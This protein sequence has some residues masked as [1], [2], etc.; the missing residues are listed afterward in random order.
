MTARISPQETVEQALAL[1]KADGCVVL[2]TEQSEANLRWANNTVTTNGEMRS[3][4]LAVISFV[5]GGTGMAAGVVEQSSTSLDVLA[6]VVRASE[7][8]A[9]DAGPADDDAP[10]VEPRV[11]DAG[12][13]RWG[14]EAAATSIGVF[15]SFA[16]VLGEAFAR[17][18]AGGRRLFGFA[19]HIVTSTYL[20]SSTGLRLRHDQPTGRVEL[21]AKTPEFAR[22]SWAGRVTRDFSDIDVDR[23]DAEVTTRLGWSQRHIELG[24]GRYQTIMS[25]AAV[26]DL[27]VYQYLATN[28]RDSDEGRTVFSRP[29]GGSRIGERLTEQ[30]LTMRSDPDEPG[31]S[32]SPFLHTSASW[33][34]ASVFD[35]GLPTGP[36]RWID[37]GVLAE[38]PRTR[39][40]AARTG[41]APAPIVDNLVLEAPGA[42]ATQDELV[43]TTDRG[44]L[45]TCL[46]YVREVDPQ[47]LLLTGLTRDGVYLVEDGEVVGAVN[48]F[49]FNESPVSLL[50]RAAEVGR[51]E[52]CLPREFSDYFTLTAAPWLRIPDFNMS[53]VSR[54]V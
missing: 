10:L 49:R 41:A 6:D 33:P 34:V 39:N 25:P 26:A 52:R 35:N 9:H 3:R 43:A 38:L 18:R 50:R 20:G 45:L 16:P 4:R 23:L 31:L 47:T 36:V 14:D 17:A 29:G 28:A 46:H 19:E 8:A 1:S 40:W 54:G 11:S 37:N 51:T 44:L 32:C 13:A 2:V 12:A 30:P 5:N 22:S 21:N 42:T 7:Q 15:G 27:I 48:N 53:T 24:A